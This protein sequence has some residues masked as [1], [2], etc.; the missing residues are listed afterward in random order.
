M[1]K[2]KIKPLTFTDEVQD[3]EASKED[4][5]KRYGDVL[6]FQKY[7]KFSSDILNCIEFDNRPQTNFKIIASL[8]T[9]TYPAWQAN[10]IWDQFGLPD[11]WSNKEKTKYLT[12]RQLVDIAEAQDVEFRCYIF[13]WNWIERW[14]FSS[15]ARMSDFTIQK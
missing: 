6:L 10:D 8:Y 2:N 5:L 12:F 4:L 13:E 14:L 3:K 1:E 9:K 15:P 11:Q 7:S